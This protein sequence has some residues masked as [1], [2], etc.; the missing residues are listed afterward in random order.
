MDS[1]FTIRTLQ[2]SD[3]KKEYFNLLAQLTTSPAICYSQFEQFV[4]NLNPYHQI[5][6]IEDLLTNKIVG[7]GTILI[8][9]K[10]IHGLGKVAHIEDIVTDGS[11]RG[12]GL[13][14]QLI[15]HLVKQAQAAGCYKVILDC[16]EHNVGFYTKC[17][18]E[19]KGVQMAK[20]F[21]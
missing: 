20:Y 14:A 11:Y 9:F 5:I 7:T 2:V 3:Y 10:L 6:V 19:Q 17:G 8:E 4:N 18:F 16:G 12:Q 15:N 13:G 21:L 1:K